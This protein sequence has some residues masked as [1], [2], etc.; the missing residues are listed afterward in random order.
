LDGLGSEQEPNKDAAEGGDAEEEEARALE[1]REG[2]EGGRE[3]RVGWVCEMGGRR[4]GSRQR[5]RG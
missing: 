2:R 1:E 4:G 3:G 5:L